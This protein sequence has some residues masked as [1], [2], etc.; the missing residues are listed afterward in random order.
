M[1][2]LL[3][4]KRVTVTAHVLNKGVYVLKRLKKYFVSYLSKCV[5]LLLD[6][7]FCVVG[8]ILGF[9]ARAQYKHLCACAC[10][11]VLGPGVSMY[12]MYVFTKKVY[13]YCTF[14]RYLESIAQALRVLTLD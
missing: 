3:F 5:V 10:L 14:I 7:R 1:L 2:S 6:D 9:Y 4:A 13:K 8:C 11:F 12:N